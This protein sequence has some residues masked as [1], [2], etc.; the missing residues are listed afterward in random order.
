MNEDQEG[1]ETINSA[2]FSTRDSF[3]Q[4]MDGNLSNFLNLYL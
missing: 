3:A 1:V 4:D 2:R